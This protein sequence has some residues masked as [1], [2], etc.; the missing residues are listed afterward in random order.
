MNSWA[1]FSG[2]Y[3]TNPAVD[4]QAGYT[5]VGYPAYANEW[6]NITFG[7]GKNPLGDAEG[8]VG[9]TMAQINAKAA[10]WERARQQ[11]YGAL[12]GRMNTDLGMTGD[13]YGYNSYP[14]AVQ[15]A[16]PQSNEF[17][18][19]HFDPKTGGYVYDNPNTPLYAGMG[20]TASQTPQTASDYKA[21]TGYN[22]ALT[23]M[24]PGPW[25]PPPASYNGAGSNPK[26]A[27]DYKAGSTYNPALA[28]MNPGPTAQPSQP[29]MLAAQTT[30][31]RD[32]P[33][34]TTGRPRS[35]GS[36]SCSTDA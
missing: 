17:A 32:V 35:E 4:P 20:N 3:N 8:N 29:N 18:G 36:S 21:P 25:T 23:A 10:A 5:G 31:R 2:S 30:P 33:P 12:Q 11:K 26:T 34:T 9:L 19:Q 27:S 6:N 13:P 1:N 15:A 24:N 7:S 14:D 28:A 16:S 22:P